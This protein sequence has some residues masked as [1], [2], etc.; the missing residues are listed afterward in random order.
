MNQKQWIFFGEIV[1][2]FVILETFVEIVNEDD[3]DNFFFN[4]QDL[5]WRQNNLI[6]RLLQRQRVTIQRIQ[7][8][9]E[10]YFG[11]YIGNW[12]HRFPAIQFLKDFR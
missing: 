9:E 1:R 11:E 7:E 8:G 3:D 6:A 12:Y 10:V 4:L 5:L 2:L